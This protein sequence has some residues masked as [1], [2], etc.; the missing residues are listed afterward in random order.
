MAADLPLGSVVVAAVVDDPLEP[1]AH[2]AVLRSI[3]TDPFARMAAHNQIDTAQFAAGRLWQLYR[4]RSEV[5]GVGAIDPTR[6]AVDGGRYKEP[7]IS[8]MSAALVQ[9]RR[10]D[11][12][13]QPYEASIVYDVLARNMAITDIA[14]ARSI[15][16]GR[17]IMSLMDS[18]RGA[19][20]TLAEVY[21]L[22]TIQR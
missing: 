1:G 2:V 17:Q 18:F 8:T 20:D 13:L 7:D 11:T 14:A 5:G 15:T 6:L 21:G 16:S 22:S 9:L 3:R 19:L 4:E 10:A 12:A